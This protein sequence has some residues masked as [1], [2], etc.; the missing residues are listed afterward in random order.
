MKPNNTLDLFTTRIPVYRVELVHERSITTDVVTSPA[1]VAPLACEYLKRADRE[2]FVVVMLATNL[3]IIGF[4]TVHIGSISASVVRVADVFKAP[5]LANAASVIVLHNHPSG[6]PEP[7]REDIRISNKLV[8]A[9]KLLECP[10]LDS[11]IVTHE[12]KYTSLAERGL[13]S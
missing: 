5:I 10:V 6:N 2:H 1:E 8:E 9:G 13:L 12:G 11:L 4:H 3:R 7:S